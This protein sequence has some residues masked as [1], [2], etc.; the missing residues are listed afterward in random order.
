[1]LARGGSGSILLLLLCVI[2]IPLRR[3]KNLGYPALVILPCVLALDRDRPVE[4]RR[5]PSLCVCS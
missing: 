2:V 4:C 3:G 5:P 1:M